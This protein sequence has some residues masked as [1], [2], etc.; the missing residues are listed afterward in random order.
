MQNSR[1]KLVSKNYK[2]VSRR[3]LLE[4]Y[5]SFL[6]LK[7]DLSNIV[8][9]II[10]MQNRRRKPFSSNYKEVSLTYLLQGYTIFFCI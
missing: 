9:I 4:S 3:Y 6:H 2:E 7:T 10:K 5:T 8:L 1:R